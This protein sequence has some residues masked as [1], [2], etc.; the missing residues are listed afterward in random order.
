MSNN[1]PFY[2]K[3]K[4]TK[5]KS[6]KNDKDAHHLAFMDRKRQDRIEIMKLIIAVLI[7]VLLVATTL[8]GRLNAELLFHIVERLITLFITV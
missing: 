5:I 7:I 3:R 2:Y 1:K 4:S 6:D 8:T